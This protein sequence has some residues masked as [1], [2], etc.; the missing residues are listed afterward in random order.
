[1][2]KL[3]KLSQTLICTSI[4]AAAAYS[5]NNAASAAEANI[6]ALKLTNKG[7]YTINTVNLKWK[8]PKDNKHY[9]RNEINLKRHYLKN[10]P[11]VKV[12]NSKQNKKNGLLVSGA[13][14]RVDLN[15]I[16]NQKGDSNRPLPDDHVWLVGHINL[17]ETKSCCRSSHD[18]FIRW[19]VPHSTTT[20]A[21]EKS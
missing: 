5:G 10:R 1:M 4:I 12:S 18:A 16:M 15:K 20:V 17:G 19:G 13:V 8:R 3:T 21:S 9:S 6:S 7:A 14:L 2:T 11:G